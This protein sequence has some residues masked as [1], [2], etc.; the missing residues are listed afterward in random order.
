VSGSRSASDTANVGKRGLRA[1]APELLTVVLLAA[2]AIAFVHAE[3]QKLKRSPLTIVAVDETFAPLC[4]C[5][6]A[7]ANIAL[8]LRARSNVTLAIVDDSGEVVR[9]LIEERRPRGVRVA[10]RWDGLDD[11]GRV[12]PD[13]DYRPQLRV[14]RERRTFLLTRRIRVDTVAPTI[15]SFRV[16]PSE[17]VRAERTHVIFSFRISERAQPLVYVNGRLATR[18]WWRRGAA[19]LQWYARR[20]GKQLRPGRYRVHLAGRD[21]AG[22]L[23]PP[24]EAVIVRVRRGR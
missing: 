1:Y 17:L 21:E 16:T 19:R 23:G 15:S 14:A 20:A 13:G 10:V 18:G 8:E 12:V 5:P 4:G 7:Q 9:T 22:N 6:R 24:S 11:N 3:R 2:T